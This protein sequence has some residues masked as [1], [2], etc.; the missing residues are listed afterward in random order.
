MGCRRLFVLYARSLHRHVVLALGGFGGSHSSL[1]LRFDFVVFLRRDDTFLIE[2]LDAVERLAIDAFRHLGFLIE[3]VG[4]LY[5][6]ATRPVLGLHI[7]GIHGTTGCRSLRHLGFHLRRID[8]HDGIALFDLV[9]LLKSELLDA[10]RH[11]ARH[12]VFA[13]F[14]FTGDELFLL[15]QGK[16]SYQGYYDHYYEHRYQ[17]E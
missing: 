3:F 13:G 8:H 1:V 14:G 2:P 10:S 6:L 4:T 7:D 17:S 12:T 5:L 9:A 16:H 15:L 11:F